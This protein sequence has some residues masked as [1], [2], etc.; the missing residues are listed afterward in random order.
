MSHRP[1]RDRALNQLDRHGDE[2]QPG[3]PLE[4]LAGEY[5]A[6]MMRAAQPSGAE[7][8]ARLRAAFQTRPASNEEKTA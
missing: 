4:W 8:A 5:L 3:T 6:G 7:M 1:N 2:A